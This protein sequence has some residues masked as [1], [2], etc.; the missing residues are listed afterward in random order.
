MPESTRSEFATHR[1]LASESRAELLRLLRESDRAMAIGELAEATGLHSNTAREHLNILIAA[2]FVVSE[3]VNAGG[4]GRPRL[5]YRALPVDAVP[6]PRS[7]RDADSLE[8]LCRVLAAQAAREQF[9][10]STTWDQ[11]Q[12]SARQWV[13]EHSDD[14]PNREINTPDEAID[15][16]TEI[17]AERGFEPAAIHEEQRV[18]LHA[19][20]YSELAIEQQQVVCGAHLGLLLGALERADSPVKARFSD[21][22]PVTPRCVIQ[23]VEP[24]V[25]R[26]DPL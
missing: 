25:T 16:I 17:L 13:H 18:V 24:P 26:E 8:L 14:I 21:I 15:L 2:H 7:A 20:P 19:C 23:L 10:S 1:A 4:R 6:S 5:T 12:D 3:Q 22:D 11:V 9:G